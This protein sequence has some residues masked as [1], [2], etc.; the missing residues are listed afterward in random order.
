MDDKLKDEKTDEKTDVLNSD[1]KTGDISATPE[2]T[3]KDE[4]QKGAHH[5]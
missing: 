3:K 4:N 2:E 5:K 1:A